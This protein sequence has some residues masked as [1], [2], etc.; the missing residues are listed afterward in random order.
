[1]ESLP[2]WNVYLHGAPIL[3]TGI[4]DEAQLPRIDQIT[5]KPDRDR[6]K[7][8]IVRKPSWKP[9]DALLAPER[10]DR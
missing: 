9:L 6:K 8:F 2:G 3:I 10:M 4:L 5:A 7:Y 1:M